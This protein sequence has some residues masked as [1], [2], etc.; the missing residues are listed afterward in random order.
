MHGI[1][2]L[3]SLDTHSEPTRKPEQLVQLDMLQHPQHLVL[4]KSANTK[5]G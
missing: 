3:Q 5:R 2:V 4:L 1:L